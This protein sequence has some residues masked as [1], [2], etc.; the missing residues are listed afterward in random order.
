MAPMEPQQLPKPSL[1][2]KQAVGL[3]VPMG[4]RSHT[5]VLQRPLMVSVKRNTCELII[6]YMLQRG[7][8]YTAL[9]VVQ[10]LYT[11]SKPDERLRGS[12]D[13]VTH[14]IKIKTTRSRNAQKSHRSLIVV[15]EPR[16][17]EL[18][19]RNSKR[20]HIQRSLGMTGNWYG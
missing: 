5:I 9:T 17:T 20:G 2:H 14:R 12:L 3:R 7:D 18:Q 1:P 11:T 19:S 6:D 10:R 8:Q 13:R 16:L 4:L 15:G